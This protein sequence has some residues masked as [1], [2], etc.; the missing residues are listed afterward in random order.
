VV[1]WF[2]EVYLPA[3]AIGNPPKTQNLDISNEQPLNHFDLNFEI[4]KGW[5]VQW[6]F[7]KTLKDKIYKKLAILAVVLISA[8]FDSIRVALCPFSMYVVRGELLM[9]RW[10]WVRHYQLVPTN[11]L[12]LRF[13]D[14]IGLSGAESYETC[15]QLLS[16][17]C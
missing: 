13:L 10:V 2:P 8:H 1:S 9:I 14:N 4:F 17:V 11:K 7:I 6:H 15:D 16:I 12:A 3:Q 5:S